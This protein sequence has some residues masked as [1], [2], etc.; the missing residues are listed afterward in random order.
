MSIKSVVEKIDVL[1]L[2]SEV[3]E[4]KSQSKEI[5]KYLQD[6][7]KKKKINAD[8][9]LGGSFAKGTL[10]KSE[11]YDIDFFIRFDWRYENISGILEEVVSG[12][13]KKNGWIIEKVHGSRDYF[14]AYKKEKIIFEIIPVVKIKKPDE[15]RNVTDLSYFHVNYV[16]KKIKRDKNLAREI[17]TAKKFLKAHKAYGAE[18]YIGGFSG[19]SIE[20][21][22][23]YYGSFIKMIRDFVKIKERKVID[24]ERHYKRKSDVFFTLNESKLHSPIILIDPTWKERNALAALREET[25]K[26][27]QIEIENFLNKP[28]EEF[29]VEKKVEKEELERYRRKIKNGQLLQLRLE[30]DRQ[31]G[32]IAATKMK[33]FS[34]FLEREIGREFE[35][36]KKEFNYI[37]GRESEVLLVVKPKNEIVIMGPPLNMEK[38]VRKFREKNK[39]VFKRGE[40]LYARRKAESSAREFIEKWKSKYS[41]LLKEMAI[42]NMIIKDF[43]K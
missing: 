21:L 29:F 15:A 42:E 40:Y 13:G 32:D 19:Y 12:L 37:G 23:I 26:K 6:S 30:T 41:Y 8:V 27:V 34:N 14:R 20:C 39:D 24:P 4:I 11:S 9:F 36:F 7:L 18:S 38:A 31:E 22:V 43:S 17:L 28:S 16:R 5:V 25:F 10:M 1:P 35:V 3:N 33:K 2:R